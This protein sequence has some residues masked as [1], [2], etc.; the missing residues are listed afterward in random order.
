MVPGV[1]AKERE[2]LLQIDVV[3]GQDTLGLFDDDPDVERLLELLRQQLRV[4]MGAV[5]GH[6][7]ALR[8]RM[9]KA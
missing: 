1:T 2:R 3:F 7:E 6:A 4:G 8:T 5:L 9:G